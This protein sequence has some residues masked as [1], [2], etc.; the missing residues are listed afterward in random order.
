MSQ[1]TQKNYPASTEDTS[2]MFKFNA[3]E[4]AVFA[5]GAEL[6]VLPQSAPEAAFSAADSTGHA[7]END[8]F[9]ASIAEDIQAAKKTNIAPLVKLILPYMALFI[10]GVLAYYFFFSKLSFPSLFNRSQKAAVQSAKETALSQLEKQ[11]MDAYAVWIKSYYF[12]V[13]DAEMLDP[14]G[15]NSGNGLTNFQ[16]FMLKLNPKAYDTLGLGVSDTESLSQGVNPLTGGK[17]TED[18]KKI[19]DNYIDM[20]VAMNRLALA[21]VQ[22]R[23]HV[24][25]ATVWSGLRGANQNSYFQNGSGNSMRSENTGSGIQNNNS[26]FNLAPVNGQNPVQNST[27]PVRTYQRTSPATG[28]SANPDPQ[29]RL[30]ALKEVG[31]GFNVGTEGALSQTTSPWAESL[32]SEALGANAKTV[33]VTMN[34]A[35]A[36]VRPI[37]LMPMPKTKLLA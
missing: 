12:D 16:K 4:A 6:P 9:E 18:Q 34:K 8:A 10:V 2:K 21:N 11:N 28:V 35:A 20:E 22:G 24:A 7:P 37:F 29:A 3:P 15:D 25:G 31:K 27:Q 32:G 17:L 13:S 23:A 30:P 14:E 33:A 36:A 1:D 26:S 19:L 5:H